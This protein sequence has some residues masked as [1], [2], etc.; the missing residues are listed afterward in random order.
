MTNSDKIKKARIKA[1]RISTA[2]LYSLA[3]EQPDEIVKHVIYKQAQQMYGK[4][5]KLGG[6]FSR[7]TGGEISF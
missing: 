7:F 6:D 2:A 3:D 1:L 5:H 4:A